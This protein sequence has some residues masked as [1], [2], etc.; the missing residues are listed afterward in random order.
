MA[1]AIV[2]VVLAIVGVVLV[3][4]GSCARDFDGSGCVLLRLCRCDTAQRAH[5]WC[6]D[7]CETRLEALAVR[8]RDTALH[9]SR[10]DYRVRFHPRELAFGAVRAIQ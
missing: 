4:A 3:S 10:Y 5:L 8:T 7:S 2:G 1:L 6:R 9:R